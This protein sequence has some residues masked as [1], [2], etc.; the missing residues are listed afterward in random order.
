MQKFP[1]VEIEWVD[2]ATL[3]GWRSLDSHRN[4]GLLVCKSAGY[5]IKKTT[6]EVQIIQS[7]SEED[8]FT[9][10]ITIPRSCVKSIKILKAKS[11]TIRLSE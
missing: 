4:S 6:K 9:E 7:F 8:Q 2:T 5:L 3:R 10:S 11:R 1:I